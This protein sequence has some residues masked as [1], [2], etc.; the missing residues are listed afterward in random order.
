MNVNLWTA[1]ECSSSI[2]KDLRSNNPDSSLIQLPQNLCTKSTSTFLSTSQTKRRANPAHLQLDPF[3]PKN[4]S[5]YNSA[6]ESDIKC[7]TNILNKN[8]AAFHV[9]GPR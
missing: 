4:K 9:G 2:T 8:K 3:P 6:I 5:Q 7:Q 1:F